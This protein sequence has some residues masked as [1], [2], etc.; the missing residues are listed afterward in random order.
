MADWTGTARYVFRIEFRLEAGAAGLSMEPDRFETVLYRSA[1]PPGHSGWLFFR[2]TLW[3]G[4]LADPE[5]FRRLAGEALGVTV[6]DATFSELRIDEPSLAA[7]RTAVGDHLDEFKADSVDA[8]ISKYLG[9]SIRVVPD[10]E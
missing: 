9:S 7:L 10:A 1:D 5:H 6:T 4:E 3:R 8:A 2:D